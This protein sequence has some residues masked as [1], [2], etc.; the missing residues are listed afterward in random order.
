MQKN[1]YYEIS[2]FILPCIIEL[3]LFSMISVVNLIMVG[4]IGPEAISAVGL[5]SQPVNMSLA[6]FQSFNIGATAL[7]ARY[8]GSK[9]YDLAKKVVIQAL[10]ISFLIGVVL[11]IPVYIFSRNIVLL[12]GAN[13]ESVI[14]ATIYM[15]FMALGIIFQVIPLSI[16]S[17]FRG[18]GD[19]KSPMM[20]NIIANII[21]VILGYLLIF[22]NMGFPRLGIYGAGLS[23]TIA[24]I[25]QTVLALV[26]LFKTKMEIRLDVNI[27]LG[28]DK[29]ILSKIIN[30]GSASAIEQIILRVGFFLYTRTIA[31]LGTIDFAA[32]QVCLNISGLSTN[33]GHALGMASTSF[34]GRL[35]GSNKRD[36]LGEYI[37]KLITIGLIISVLISIL[38]IFKGQSVASIYTNDNAIINKLVPIMIILSLINPAQN[39][40]LVLSGALKGAGET[41][42]PLLT[43]L[44]G[45]LVI[46]IPLVLLF[47]NYLNFGL[48]GAWVA[49][50]IDKY[51]SLI[52][53]RIGFIKGKWRDRDI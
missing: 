10:Q 42:W 11:T 40:V 4:K 3:M 13:S 52:I 7:I 18:A 28:L 5:T 32:H 44:I 20:I 1:Q 34:T 26:L 19:S 33:F 39:S 9:S 23:A 47:V 21:N 31:N 43:S 35:L 6:V 45:L 15:K 16:S 49:T 46:R 17:L 2:K 12:I 30:I 24:K 27:N 36:I 25:I 41:R 48:Y 8:V 38:F 50:L 14:N 22:G 51:V 37:K 53:L 29:R